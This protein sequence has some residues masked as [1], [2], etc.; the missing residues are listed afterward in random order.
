MSTFFTYSCGGQ[1]NKMRLVGLKTKVS[2]ELVPSAG[3]RKKSAPCLFLLLVITASLGLWFHHF[4]HIVFSFSVAKHFLLPLAKIPV[5]IFRAR[6]D[7]SP[8]LRSLTTHA[9][10]F[11]CKVTYSQVLGHLWTL[12]FSYDRWYSHFINEETKSQR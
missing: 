12:L 5:I 10:S 4:S 3:A 2:T 1:E 11:P 8:I 7:N 9:Q 6:K